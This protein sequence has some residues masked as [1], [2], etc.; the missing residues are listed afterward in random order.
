MTLTPA[1]LQLLKSLEGCSLEAYPDPPGGSSWSIGYGLNS[2]DVGP[3]QQGVREGL[4]LRSS[5]P[6]SSRAAV[7]VFV[8]SISRSW[9]FLIAS[10]SVAA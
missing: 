7:P 10:G 2:P 3:G 8:A 4:E 9:S 6:P 1:G 5:R